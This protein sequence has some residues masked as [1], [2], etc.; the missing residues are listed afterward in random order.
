MFDKIKFKNVIRVIL[1]SVAVTGLL[2]AQRTITDWQP[3]FKGVEHAVGFTDQ[4]RLQ[5][6]NVLRI[7]LR[8]PNISF[9]TTPDNGSEPN[10]TTNET[11]EDYIKRT[12]VQACINTAFFSRNKQDEKYTDIIG[13]SIDQGKVVSTMPKTHSTPIPN[14]MAILLTK[15]NKARVER[16]TADCNIAGVWTA[17]ECWPA[18]VEDGKNIGRDVNDPA[19]DN[20]HPRSAVGLTKSKRHLILMV[21]D[22]R[23]EGYSM[24]ATFAE[25]ADW[26][27]EFGAY[28]GV[29]LDGGG[30]SHMWI[31]TP[32]GMK[33][34]N[35][36]SE[37]RAVGAHL[38]IYAP[39]FDA[40]IKCLN[41]KC[42]FR[43]QD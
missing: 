19:I 5:Q 37:D 41:N 40:K 18:L 3:I 31:N 12:G 27:I 26:L 14:S 21:I 4:P 30:S 35:K 8:E 6:V 24:G 1:L 17:F 28:N 22:G 34:L 9:I 23:Q 15:D 39:S 38:G 29:N 16:N 2:Y 11:A 36:P 43:R 20:V 32:Q 25:T 42:A 10:D 7:D 33:A 13:L